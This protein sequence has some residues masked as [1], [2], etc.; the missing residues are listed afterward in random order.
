MFFLWLYLSEFA[1]CWLL[2]WSSS[3]VR[4]LCFVLTWAQTWYLD[5]CQDSYNLSLSEQF[6]EFC[7]PHVSNSLVK[8]SYRVL[9]I[10]SWRIIFPSGV[11]QQHV[12]EL[13]IFSICILYFLLVVSWSLS[14][15]GSGNV[16]DISIGPTGL[17]AICWA[18]R[19]ASWLPPC[20]R[21]VIFWISLAVNGNNS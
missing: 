10:V 19:S 15:T 12:S 8:F 16:I 7:G 6:R 21:G 1:G 18:A 20:I 3:C 13:F 5:P 4:A 11:L 9:P 17:R 2:I 14:S